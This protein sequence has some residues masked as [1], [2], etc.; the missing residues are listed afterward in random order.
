[1]WAAIRRPQTRG[2]RQDQR[3]LRDDTRRAKEAL[4]TE[5]F[6]DVWVA[7]TSQDVVITREQFVAMIE[8]G[9]NRSVELLGETLAA[10]DVRPD[11]LSALFLTGGSSRIPLVEERVRERFGRAD[12]QD[13]PKS[14][15]A[16]GAARMV[17][18]DVPTGEPAPPARVSRARSR[19][20]TR[21]TTGRRTRHRI[22]L[23]RG[24]ATV[25]GW[26]ACPRSPAAR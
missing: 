18:A 15:V 4:S 17:V 26:S 3:V 1:M 16:L 10:A 13:D 6:V 5:T 7:R 22:P 12:T 11:Q 9:I 25:R 20:A 23:R 14:I 21:R 24:R 8:G 2:D 19:G